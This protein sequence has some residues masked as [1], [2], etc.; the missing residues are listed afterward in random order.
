MYIGKLHAKQIS[1]CIIHRMSKGE[2]KDDQSLC[3][4]TRD[5]FLIYI[6]T[7]FGLFGMYTSWYKSFIAP[8]HLCICKEMASLPLKIDINIFS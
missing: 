7:R 6:R 1:R 4:I 2:L 3:Q 5:N 8:S